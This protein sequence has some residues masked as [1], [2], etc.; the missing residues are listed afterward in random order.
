MVEDSCNPFVWC[1]LRIWLPDGCIA[2]CWV[3]DSSFSKAF[4]LPII[5]VLLGKPLHPLCHSPPW[6]AVAEVIPLY[7]S[8]EQ[9]LVAAPFFWKSTGMAVEQ[10][11]RG[12]KVQMQVAVA[13]DAGEIFLSQAVSP[14]QPVNLSYCSCLTCWVYKSIWGGFK[15]LFFSSLCNLLIFLHELLLLSQARKI[16][17]I[18]F[19]IC[20]IQL[21]WLCLRDYRSINVVHLEVKMRLQSLESLHLFH[22]WCIDSS[23]FSV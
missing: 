9:F 3:Y 10:R 13:F 17:R 8:E 11:T 23:P 6:K 19:G 21:P 15:E 4:S 5:F 22:Y 20:A 7:Q 1:S 12:R 2:N 14:Q 18:I 16:R